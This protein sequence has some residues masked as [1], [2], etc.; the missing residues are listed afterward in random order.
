MLDVCRDRGIGK[1]VDEGAFPDALK[2]LRME[3]VEG[4]VQRR[5]RQRTATVGDDGGDLS[6]R[7]QDALDLVEQAGPMHT[8]RQRVSPCRFS[9]MNGSGGAIWNPGN[10]RTAR[11]IPNELIE[12]PETRSRRPPGLEDR[13]GEDLVDL[14]KPIFPRGDDAETPPPPRSPQKRSALLPLAR[15]EESP[16]SSYRVS[17]D[18]IVNR[19]ADPAG[20]VAD[21][22]AQHETGGA[23]RRDDP[24]RAVARRRCASHS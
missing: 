5:I 20:Q 22:S 10:L 21:A 4:A 19:Q 14:V 12:H 1:V 23:R 13:P 6:E 15:G 11:D 2:A 7:F 16:F 3:A 9:G 8:T 17:R 18:Q 24:A